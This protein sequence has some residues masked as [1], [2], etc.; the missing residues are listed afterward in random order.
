MIK[1]LLY[2]F[3]FSSI[4]TFAQNGLDFDGVNDF[5]NTNYPGISG[6]NP[7]TV[8][9]WIKTT[10]NADPGNGGS[11]KTIVDWGTFATGQRF[12]FNV[13]WANAI[14]LEVQG[15]GISG[16]IA[17]NDGNWHHVAAVFDPNAAN[18]VSLY[19]DG[20]LDV[21]GN[22][23]VTVNTGST[24]PVRIGRRID[25]VNSFNGSI[26]EVR[27][28]NVAKTQAEIQESMNVE[29]CTPQS[30]LKTYYK[31]NQGT[32]GGTN[33]TENTLT[34]SS[35]N[36]Y[37][38]TLGNF[39][40]SGSTSNWIASQTLPMATVNNSI[41]NDNS[42]TL[43]ATVTGATYQWID[44]NNANTPISGATSQTFSPSIVGSYAVQLSK[45]GCT[46]TSSCESVTTLGI[47]SNEFASSILMFPNPTNG[48]T[49]IQLKNSFETIEATVYNI[50]G[51][52]ILNKNF[53]NT[54]SFTININGSNGIYFLA[55]KTNSGENAVL[56]I[57]K[58]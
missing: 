49:N 37:T 36:N 46:A 30:S 4:I 25:E 47:N 12:T 54:N 3:L 13:L 18:K 34:D 43:T 38:G 9:A 5:V 21:A 52:T 56:K 39:A 48:I 32:A 15:N 57:L 23:T 35:G 19:V 24:L 8:E 2:L 33:T 26:D 53:S 10:A 7:R 58:N 1:K 44:C 45:N 6:S 20:V 55:I 22:L 11:Q 31:F 42:G 50:T 51:Q 14:R 17:V 29:L 16:T 40:L 27:I 41:T 28:W